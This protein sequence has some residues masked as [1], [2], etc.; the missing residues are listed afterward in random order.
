MQILSRILISLAWWCTP[1][2]PA[3]K[4]QREDG[5]EFKTSLGY[6]VRFCL[7]NK[8]TKIKSEKHWK[9]PVGLS[10]CGGY[11]WPSWESSQ[12][13]LET[14]VRSLAMRVRTQTAS[15]GN[16][17]RQGWFLFLVHIC[18][19]KERNISRGKTPVRRAALSY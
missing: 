9:A 15:L 18:V 13:V 4:R 11:C 14:K 6:I 1:V 17:W 10:L 5:F 16:E 2:I 8:Q 12:D 3:L 19:F 7:K